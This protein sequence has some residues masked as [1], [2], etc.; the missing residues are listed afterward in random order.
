MAEE[1]SVEKAANML[2]VHPRTILRAVLGE[3][4]PNWHPG[5]EKNIYIGKE[6]LRQKYVIPA[7]I[8]DDV[9]NGKDMFHTGRELREEF[10]IK[11]DLFKKRKYPCHA[12]NGKIVRYSRSRWINFHF[13]YYY[14]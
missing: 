1:I 5:V 10:K 8:L 4:N 9:L 6:Q 14:G 3:D 12:R 11:Y 13:Y 7:K 2:K